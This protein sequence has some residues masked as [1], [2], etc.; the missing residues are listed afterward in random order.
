MRRFTALAAAFLA[1]C[2]LAAPLFADHH[3]SGYRADFLNDFDRASKKL[4]DL[5]EAMPEDIFTWRLTDE[6]RSV[7]EIFMHVASTNYYLA[8]DLGVPLPEGLSED[9]E[10]DVTAKADVI[11]TLNA[12][13]D[14]VR[15]AV[16]KNEDLDREIELSASNARCAACS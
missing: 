8:R 11:A 15:Q 2:M 16:E 4:A 5:A 10:K 1:T 9:L 7:S 12:S 13:L 3:L 14:H 6:V